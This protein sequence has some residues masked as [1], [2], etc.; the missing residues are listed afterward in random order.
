VWATRWL[1]PLAFGLG[2]QFGLEAV[3]GLEGP[4]LRASQI[5]SETPSL[6]VAVLTGAACVVRWIRNES[7]TVPPLRIR[8]QDV[9]ALPRASV[10][11]EAVPAPPGG[12]MAAVLAPSFDPRRTAVVEG[13]G[14]LTRRAEW[15]RGDASVRLRSRRTGSVELAARLPAE[16]ILVLAQSYERGWR[17]TVDGRPAPVF[18]ANAAFLGIRLPAG[19]HEVRFDYRPRGLR[20]GAALAAAGALGLVLA[21]LRLPTATEP[22]S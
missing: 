10:V 6:K 17:A 3:Q 4:T 13:T 20:E 21:A 15:D 2:M 18:R 22:P 14:P 11:P 7:G 9:T 19:L 5:L 12:A 16:G 1:E 8:I